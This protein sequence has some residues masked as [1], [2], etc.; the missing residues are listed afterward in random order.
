MQTNIARNSLLIA[1]FALMFSLTACVAPP[2]RNATLI[3]EPTAP[4]ASPTVQLTLAPTEP[5]KQASAMGLWQLDMFMLYDLRA[6]GTISAG[7]TFAGDPPYTGEW[8]TL[9]DGR[10]HMKIERMGEMTA[11]LHDNV[12]V[13]GEAPNS[14]GV[15]VMRRLDAQGNV[16]PANI[17]TSTLPLPL[18]DSKKVSGVKITEI[19]WGLS[20]DAPIES[21]IT[22]TLSAD[23]ALGHVFYSKGSD[24]P[25][26]TTLPITVPMS[27][28]AGALSQWSQTPVEAGPYRPFINHTDDYPYVR[29][30]LTLPDGN[31]VFETRSQGQDNLPWK[32]MVNGAEYVSFSDLPSSAM[33]LLNPFLARDALQK[34]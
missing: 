3:A 12:L 33:K 28:M 18:F 26:S 20:P 13:V 19:W 27:V 11:T 29:I 24:K 21:Q 9:P 16:L 31:V 23:S 25:V 10:I 1:G 32:V 15:M 2:P 7:M 14:N 5:A 30:E 22:L 34:L 4:P 17:S 6:D 8:R